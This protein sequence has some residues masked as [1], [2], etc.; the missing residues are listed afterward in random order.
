MLQIVRNTAVLQKTQESWVMEF[1]HCRS[2]KCDTV[3]RTS[4]G[5]SYVSSGHGI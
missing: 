2:G 3:Y 5:Q 1:N 4:W